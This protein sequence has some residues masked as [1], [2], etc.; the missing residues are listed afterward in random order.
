MTLEFIGHLPA[1]SKVR[2]QDK[3]STTEFGFDI[4]IPFSKQWEQEV[5]HGSKSLRG[6]KWSVS[7]KEQG[8]TNAGGMTEEWTNVFKAFTENFDTALKA[9]PT[10][11]ARQKSAEMASNLADILYDAQKVPTQSQGV[12]KYKATKGE[13]EDYIVMEYNRLN[14]EE[15][16]WKHI[17]ADGSKVEGPAKLSSG[18]VKGEGFSTLSQKSM[19]F[20]AETD[21]EA[22]NLN[23]LLNRIAAQQGAPEGF[24][25]NIQGV[26]V[27]IE[28]SSKY[29]QKEYDKLEDITDPAK[30]LKKSAKNAARNVMAEY[31]KVAGSITDA[32]TS[33]KEKE[34][35][36]EDVF[37]IGG[38]MMD[39]FWEVTERMFRQ[40][41]GKQTAGGAYLYHIPLKNAGFSAVGEW[42][43]LVGLIRLMPVFQKTGKPSG[44]FGDLML[45]NISTQTMIIDLTDF[46]AD[47]NFSEMSTVA[48]YQYMI[49]L[50]S[51]FLIQDG[52]KNLN[53]TTIKDQL[54]G[55]NMRR[56][57]A[58][59]AVTTSM[60]T[61]LIGSS[62]WTMA[63][64]TLQTLAPEVFVQAVKTLTTP[65][66]AES[67]KNQFEDF[68]SS[69]T[70][71]G[72]LMS[73]Q[74]ALFYADAVANSQ[75]ITKS[76]IKGM[77]Q[78]WGAWKGTEN[79]IFSKQW[80]YLGGN[81]PSGQ[82]A[83]VPW[84]LNYGRDAGGWEEF[85]NRATDIDDTEFLVKMNKGD[86]KIGKDAYRGAVP[87][88]IPEGPAAGGDE[89]RITSYA[90]RF[91]RYADPA[92]LLD[93]AMTED[94]FIFPHGGT[95]MGGKGNPFLVSKKS[96][97]FKPKG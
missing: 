54:L 70:D 74:F 22:Q 17:G 92:S 18:K 90:E 95:R 80:G 33:F 49:G 43:P 32:Y 9:Y 71:S 78:D 52:I 60:R 82:G 88:Q 34:Q 67:L 27:T 96:P 75:T 76:W 24:V 87:V 30:R 79:S 26:E 77:G 20:M 28:A 81:S 85:K 39:R 50:L 23:Y 1:K 45:T 5:T 64:A 73:E 51:N 84:F 62:V 10:T 48:G 83:A 42:H 31:K 38:Q 2:P 72:K 3:F 35:E 25:K 19:D 47:G 91:H 97:F 7:P 57:I 58:N 44:G 12:G 59:V 65:E 63:N 93:G 8:A 53:S 13:L 56:Q 37:Y 29:F 68:F 6:S 89:F 61:E 4:F 11:Q 14:H 69:S 94:T 40:S 66:I 41:G 86:K 46:D 16:N 36:P 15:E 55:D 21:D